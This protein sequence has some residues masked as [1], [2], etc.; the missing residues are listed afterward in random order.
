LRQTRGTSKYPDKIKCP[1]NV[2]NTAEKWAN[3]GEG[4]GASQDVERAA[5]KLGDP[6][7]GLP[8]QTASY[9]TLMCS[10]HVRW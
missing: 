5:K 7:Q 2:G 3:A 6:L 8:P 9:G 1:Q 10:G 4:E